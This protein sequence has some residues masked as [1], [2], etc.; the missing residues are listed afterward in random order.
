MG[1]IAVAR[2]RA[3]SL[4]CLILATA[5]SVAYSVRAEQAITANLKQTLTQR[6][7]MMHD[8]A[9]YKWINQRPVED[10]EREA[11]VLTATVER[12]TTFGLDRTFATGVV[13]A[14]ISAAKHIQ[15]RWFTVW[16]VEGGPA[17]APDL[18]SELR[19]RIS[20]QT[21]ILLQQLKTFSA[22]ELTEADRQTI[23]AVPPE[24]RDDKMAWAIATA[25][26]LQGIR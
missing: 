16:A 14:Q 11:Q 8:V 19:P 25:P 18:T 17:R 20:S 12:A 22:V 7:L 4:S 26:M 1:L 10:L 9:A 5:W 2:V 23:T 3:V 6:L 21:E 15:S 13:R 24:L